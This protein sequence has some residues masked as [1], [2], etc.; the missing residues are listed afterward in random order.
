MRLKM[1]A[2]ILTLIAIQNPPSTSST[3]EGRVLRA[4]TGEPIANTPSEFAAMINS[5]TAKWS[6]IVKDANIKAE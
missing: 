1:L 3:I 5:E 6:K 2:L 4:G